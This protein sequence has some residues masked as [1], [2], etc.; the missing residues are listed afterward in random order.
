MTKENETSPQSTPK[1][2]PLTLDLNSLAAL[3]H[4]TNI[5]KG[6]YEEYI[7]IRQTLVDNNRELAAG[8]DRIF[9]AQRVA[10]IHSEV[11]EALEGNRKAVMDDHL[12]HRKME[13]VEIVDAIYRLLDVAAFRRIDLNTIIAEKYAYNNKREYLHGKKY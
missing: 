11:S 2:E 10:L 4:K 6:F 1:L 5:D 9:F 7:N 13:D 8:F 12:P 3:L